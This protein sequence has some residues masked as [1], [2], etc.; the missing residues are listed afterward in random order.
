MCA[1]AG[2]VERGGGGVAEGEAGVPFFGTCPFCWVCLTIAD[3]D[4]CSAPSRSCYHHWCVVA[5]SCCCACLLTRKVYDAGCPSYC[6][7][8]GSAGMAARPPKRAR[9]LGLPSR[10]SGMAHRSTP[11]QPQSAPTLPLAQPRSE[12]PSPLTALSRNPRS[13]VRGAL[14]LGSIGAAICTR[15]P[16]PRR[17]W[18]AWRPARPAG[19][20]LRLPL[21][22]PTTRCCCAAANMFASAAAAVLV[23]VRGRKHRSTAA[24]GAGFVLCVGDVH[25][26]TRK[27]AATSGG[28][29][30][31]ACDGT[32]WSTAP[33]SLL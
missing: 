10:C 16:A 32:R 2:R 13:S 14:V 5:H 6:G 22:P 31:C 9:A 27:V 17:G 25:G 28:A 20:R 24:R 4:C 26:D 23:V 3:G 1:C 7:L 8:V 29:E 21:T 33:K 30:L 12:S 18:A 15:T 19:K 11:S